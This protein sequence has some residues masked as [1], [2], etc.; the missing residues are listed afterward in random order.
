M[1]PSPCRP[2]NQ[3][4]LFA[5]EESFL[6]APVIGSPVS[7]GYVPI[8]AEWRVDQVAHTRRN[9]ATARIHSNADLLTTCIAVNKTLD[10]SCVRHCLF[11]GGGRW[12]GF[13]LGPLESVRTGVFEC[14]RVREREREREMVEETRRGIGRFAKFL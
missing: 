6:P 10:V 3:I 13:G 2:R 8:L 7:R 5:R 12:L 14:M 9:D 4:V 11:W 1:P